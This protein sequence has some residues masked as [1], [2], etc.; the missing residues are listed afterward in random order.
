MDEPKPCRGDWNPKLL[1]GLNG[2][3]RDG[4]YAPGDPGDPAEELRWSRLTE[5][6]GGSEET[7]SSYRPLLYRRARLN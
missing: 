1:R 4:E 7:S 6:I 3:F 2:P 5:S